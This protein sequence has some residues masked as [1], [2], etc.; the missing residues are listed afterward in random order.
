MNCFEIND[1][2]RLDFATPHLISKQVE[3][4][5]HIRV[6]SLLLLRPMGSESESN[7]DSDVAVSGLTNCS[8]QINV[9]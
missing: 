1:F 4:R 6:I 3:N 8:A 2:E 9:N 7:S 5:P